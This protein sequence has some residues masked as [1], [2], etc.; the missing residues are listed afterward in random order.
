MKE[1]GPRG[2]EV[3][4]GHEA[5]ELGRLHHLAEAELVLGDGGLARLA[6]G[7]PGL[8]VLRLPRLRRR[9]HSALPARYCSPPPSAPP[10]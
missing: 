2:V 8:G 6:R 4:H 10:S 1:N 7:P 5:V 3:T 9:C